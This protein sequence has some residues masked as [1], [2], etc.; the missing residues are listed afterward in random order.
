MVFHGLHE[1]DAF[2]KSGFGIHAPATFKGFRIEPNAASQRR[3][4]ERLEGIEPPAPG[5]GRVLLH[6]SNRD[7]NRTWPQEKWQ[8]L[9]SRLRAE[10]HQVLSIGQ[11]AAND[12]SGV[13]A[14]EGVVDLIGAF[15]PIETIALMNWAQLL[16]AT[17]SGPV[18]LAGST[19]IGIVGIYSVVAG[20]N[21]LP[22]R[23]GIPAWRALA[24]SPECSFHPCY[25]RLLV[26]DEFAAYQSG[27]PKTAQENAKFVGDWCP[28]PQRY[29]C[30][31]QEITVERVIT[32]CHTRFLLRMKVRECIYKL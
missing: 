22:Y 26:S 20:R 19:D 5:R 11:R 2:L 16:V 9:A 13:F 3:V 21:R 14:L 32:A 18:Q 29:V 7:Q 27:A 17:D 23:N 12:A 1:V 24:V 8:E 15:D 6:P 31:S 30:L 10:G 28:N 4:A 25:E